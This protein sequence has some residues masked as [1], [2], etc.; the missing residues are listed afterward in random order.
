MRDLSRVIDGLFT[1]AID[2]REYE[3]LDIML[4]SFIHQCFAGLLFSLYTLA[5]AH[6]CGDGKDAVDGLLDGFCGGK[7]GWDVVEV[8][9]YELDGRRLLL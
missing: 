6:K 5:F 9:G 4:Q 8:A 7:D 2:G 3:V 1:T